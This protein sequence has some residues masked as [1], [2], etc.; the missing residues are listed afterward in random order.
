MKASKHGKSVTLSIGDR[1]IV[2]R[3]EEAR[4]LMEELKRVLK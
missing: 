1:V 3:E 4:E 2:I